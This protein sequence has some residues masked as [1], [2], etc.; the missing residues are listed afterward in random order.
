MKIPKLEVE[1]ELQLPAFATATATPDLS[2]ICNLHLSSRQ[3]QIFNPLSLGRNQTHILMDI[4]RIHSHCTITPTLSWLLS[5][6][7]KFWKCKGKILQLFFFFLT[8]TAAH[9]SSQAQGLIRAAATTWPQ[10]SQI[11][12]SCATYAAACNT[13]S[14]SHRVRPGIEPESSWILVRFLTHWATRSPNAGSLTHCAGAGIEPASQSS[15]DTA[16]PT[17]GIPTVG[18]LTLCTTVGTLR[19]LQLCF[20][21]SR[22]FRLFWISYNSI[23]ILGSVQFVDFYKEA[24]RFWQG[25][26]WIC[27]SIWEVLPF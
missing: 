6:C 21:F 14:S 19:V 8:T 20:L 13:K 12:A 24:D 15:P 22:L 16:T 4:S 18:Y 23:W 2:C 17:V 26:S 27:R 10:Q 7:A 25:L 3:C 5:F 9:G 11:W 1:L